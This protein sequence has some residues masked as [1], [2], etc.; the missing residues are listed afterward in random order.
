MYAGALIGTV[1]SPHRPLTPAAALQA[2]VLAIFAAVLISPFDVPDPF[3]VGSALAW[4]L[5]ALVAAATVWIPDLVAGRWPATGIDWPMAG[6]G[7]AA[8]LAAF[9]SAHPAHTI[10]PLLALAA[11]LAVFYASVSVARKVP[12]AAPTLLLLLVAGIALLELMAFAYHAGVGLAVRTKGYP[13]PAGWSGYPELALVGGVEIG[14][15][16]GALQA[17]R[18]KAAVAVTSALIVLAAIQLVFLYARTAWLSVGV[19]LMLAGILAVRRQSATRVLALGAVLGVLTIGLLAASPTFRYLAGGIVGLGGAAPADWR[20]LEVAGPGAR[21][22]VWKRTLH[23]VAAHP[24]AGVG[25]GNFRE[26]FESDFDPGLG[27]TG[28]TGLHAHNL[29]LQQTAETGI[30]GGLCYLAIWVV[31][32]HHAW[33]RAR[34]RP[35]FQTTGLLLAIAGL[36]TANAINHMYSFTGDAPG[37]LY[38]LTWLLF[39]FVHAG[40]NDGAVDSEMD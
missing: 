9:L 1:P 3:R 4:P 32:L 12:L 18:R 15:L 35:S 38:S 25:P 26:V 11:Q 8:G 20:T 34:D 31:T 16:L 14:L 6:F 23:L 5:V 17:S 30:A 13:M 28:R 21:L 37:R 40:R 33:R 22:D 2:A 39:G 27:E 10:V 7:A 29:W 19:M 36:A 24:L